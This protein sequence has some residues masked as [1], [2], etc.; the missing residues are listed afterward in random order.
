[1]NCV[2]GHFLEKNSCQLTSKTQVSKDVVHTFLEFYLLRFFHLPQRNLSVWICVNVSKKGTYLTRE[3]RTAYCVHIH[4]NVRLY[5]W[6]VVDPE[7]NLILKGIPE[8]GFFHFHRCLD[9]RGLASFCQF[10]PP[11]LHLSAMIGKVYRIG[12]AKKILG[13]SERSMFRYIHDGKLR[14][15]KI[16]YWRISEAD[17]NKFVTDRTN[18]RKPK[19]K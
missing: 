3:V 9:C 18:I 19:K 17:L 5:F 6:A 15:T 14:A 10:K 1:M 7:C 2:V 4:K 16:G 12:E 13:V 11:V 8:G